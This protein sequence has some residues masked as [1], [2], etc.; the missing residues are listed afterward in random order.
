MGIDDLINFTTRT[1]LFNITVCSQELLCSRIDGLSCWT[2]LNLRI[3]ILSKGN[4]TQFNS[5]RQP[6]KFDSFKTC[7]ENIVNLL[8]NRSNHKTKD[9]VSNRL[10]AMFTL[11]ALITDID[12]EDEACHFWAA[13]SDNITKILVPYGNSKLGYVPSVWKVDLCRLFNYASQLSRRKFIICAINKLSLWPIVGRATL[14]YI[15]YEVFIGALQS[16]NL[17]MVEFYLKTWPRR[18]VWFTSGFW[19]TSDGDEYSFQLEI[20]KLVHEC[21]SLSG[22]IL[23]VSHVLLNIER[24][25]T[26]PKPTIVNGLVDLFINLSASDLN[27]MHILTRFCNMAHGLETSRGSAIISRLLELYPDL[28]IH[29]DK[30]FALKWS[31]N[32]KVPD[33]TKKLIALGAN[34]DIAFPGDDLKHIPNKGAVVIEMKPLHDILRKEVSIKENEYAK[35]YLCDACVRVASEIEGCTIEF[36]KEAL[37]KAEVEALRK[38]F[39][40]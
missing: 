11:K 3:S 24:G 1:N 16:K 8:M 7:D 39:K 18:G 37:K 19:V 38:N 12:Y 40:I 5:S 35:Y 15:F 23:F 21:A 20:L 10:L 33:I 34:I 22:R 17:Q 28:D 27:K 6:Y 36:V 26:E 30:E 9:V 4:T 2:F 13:I 29:H 32:Y 14:D 25:G 31:V